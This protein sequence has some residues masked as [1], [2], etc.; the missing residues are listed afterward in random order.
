MFSLIRCI[1]TW[2]GPSIMTCT[3]C[4]QAMSVSSPSVFS[5]PNCASSLA[6]AIEPGRRPSPSEKAH[7]VGLHDLADVLE[8]RVEEVLLVVRQAP[9][10]HDRAA[11]ADD[12]GHA[13]GGQRDVAQQHAGVDGEVVDALLGLLDQRVAED[14]PGQVLGLA[15]HLLQ[16]LVDRHG[17]DR[18]RRVAHDP[19]A[20]LVDVLAGGQVHHRVGAP[21]DRPGHLLDFLGDEEVTAELPMLALIFTRKLRP[22]IIGSSFGV[23]DVGGDDGAAAGDL[24]AHELGR[25]RPSGCRR[26]SSRRGAGAAAVRRGPSRF[27]FSRI[28]MNSISGVTMPR[29]A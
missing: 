16:R 7:V 5:S 4:F 24:V 10:G 9:L 29:R 21:A 27:W 11:A 6:S 3:S 20:G 19:L 26:R 23:V 2:P 15:V 17:A 18:H 8:V 22:M 1:G 25:D 14:L 13:L 28:A 12:A